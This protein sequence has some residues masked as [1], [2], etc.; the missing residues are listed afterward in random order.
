MLLVYTWKQMNNHYIQTER[1]S[2]CNMLLDLLLTHQILLM[3]FHSHQNMLIYIKSFGIRLSPL[4]ESAKVKPQ[5]IEKH[6]TSNIQAWCLKQ[7]ELIF[8]YYSEKKK[9]EI[10]PPHTRGICYVRRAANLLITSN[11]NTYIN[12]IRGTFFMFV[13]R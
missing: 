2:L 11:A 10:N 9:S 3:K 7:V 8:D 1:N 6:F 5:N 12:Y 4:F 13:E